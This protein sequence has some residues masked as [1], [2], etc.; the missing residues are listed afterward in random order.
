MHPLV[1]KF[2]R[3]KEVKLEQFT[4]ISFIVVTKETSNSDKSIEM[5]D[6]HPLNILLQFFIWLSHT[7]TILF[8]PSCSKLIVLI[9]P[10]SSVLSFK[11]TW[12]GE[13]NPSPIIWT[14][15]FGPFIIIVTVVVESA[16]LL[17]LNK[18]LLTRFAL[19]WNGS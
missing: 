10:K 16:N 6:E 9:L 3:F 5:I 19:F 14:F 17:L 15:S 12:F 4:N 7:I 1:T 11:Y 8:G 2:P 13:L 18:V